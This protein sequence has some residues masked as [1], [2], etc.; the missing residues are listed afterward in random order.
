[1]TTKA[2]IIQA[3]YYR[4]RI[5]GLTVNPSAED[6]NLALHR[7]ENMA[8]E[9]RALNIRTG[10][11]FEDAPLSTTRHNVPRKWWSAYE[12][13]LAFRLLADF[14]KQPVPTLTMEKSTTFSTMSGQTAQIPATQYPSRQPMGA[15]NRFKRFYAT[16]T[17]APTEGTTNTMYWGDTNDYIEHFDAYLEYGETVSSYT[18]AADDGLTIESDSLTTPDVSYQITAD[19]DSGINAAKVTIVATT[20]DSRVE[21]RI[22][23]FNL[24]DPD[25]S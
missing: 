14:G 23:N 21:T 25:A 15:G 5:S 10:Y 18:I 22:I 17:V 1:M 16:Q 7:L 11:K 9:W 3:A 8:E 20:S 2:E 19:S 12:S 24:V 6:M 13:N 4:M